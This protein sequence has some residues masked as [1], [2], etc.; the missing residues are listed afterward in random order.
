VRRGPGAAHADSL[1]RTPN[2]GRPGAA[3]LAHHATTRPTPP[4]RPVTV[5]RARE[6]RSGG[7]PCVAERPP[8][9][10]ME[11]KIDAFGVS[12][13]SLYPIRVSKLPPLAL[14]ATKDRGRNAHT[15]KRDPS[16]GLI[17]KVGLIKPVARTA[18]WSL[19]VCSSENTELVCAQKNSTFHSVVPDARSHY[20]YRVVIIKPDIRALPYC[21][22]RG[23][24]S[25]GTLA[26]TPTTT[27][28]FR[29]SAR[30]L[31]TLRTPLFARHSRQTTTLNSVFSE[32]AT[33]AIGAER[34]E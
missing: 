28:G 20:Q 1:R 5:G 8:R 6:W 2:N 7:V 13:V 22:N 31:S 11:G 4:Q 18:R 12:N 10:G 19:D 26:R 21:G 34:A 9:R 3:H 23:V 24:V 14:R 15:R 29:L 17:W 27:K 25:V 32:S 16:S 33:E 30:P